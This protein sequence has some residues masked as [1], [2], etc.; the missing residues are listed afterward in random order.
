MVSS[1]YTLVLQTSVNEGEHSLYFLFNHAIINFLSR[2]R[3][4]NYVPVVLQK[5]SKWKMISSIWQNRLIQ[6]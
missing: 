5:N 6:N 4:F 3:L 1:G 2:C